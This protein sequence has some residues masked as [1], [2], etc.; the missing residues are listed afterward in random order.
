MVLSQRSLGPV[1]RRHSAASQSGRPAVHSTGHLQQVPGGHPAAVQRRVL[2]GQRGEGSLAQG[3]RQCRGWQQRRVVRVVR[4]LK[5]IV[6][7]ANRK[8]MQLEQRQ[9]QMPRPKHCS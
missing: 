6:L 4:Q 3:A 2:W 7:C 5:A 1:A 9:T 8:R